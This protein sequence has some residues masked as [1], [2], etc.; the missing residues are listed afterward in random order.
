M[1]T[2]DGTDD[3]VL[4]RTYTMIEEILAYEEQIGRLKGT[5]NADVKSSAKSDSEIER[6]KSE[7]AKKDRD[8]DTLKKQSVGNNKAFSD[9]ADEHAK[10][11]AKAGEGKKVN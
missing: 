8:L 5:S 6:L 4:A 3:R 10:V 7:L 1:L 11:T 2:V 9:L